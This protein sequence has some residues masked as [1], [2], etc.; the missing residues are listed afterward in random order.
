[1]TIRGLTKRTKEH[2]E[3]QI[4]ALS[5]KPIKEL[6]EKAA[7]IKGEQKHVFDLYVKAVKSHNCKESER[8]EDKS[9]ELAEKENDIKEAI[10]RK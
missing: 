5:K 1:M 10:R 8:L 3:E 2:K 9:A 7:I 4:I 6:W